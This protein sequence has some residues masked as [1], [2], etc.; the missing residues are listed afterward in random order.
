MLKIL[1]II[2]TMVLFM[3]SAAFAADNIKMVSPLTA[4]TTGKSVF[5]T[6]TATAPT[7]TAQELIGKT[8]TGVGV[9]L[10][11]S[12]LGYCLVTQHINGTKAFGSAHD[13]T[14]IFA[15][16]VTTVGTPALDV[17]GAIGV[18]PVSGAGWTSM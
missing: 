9:G 18:V 3:S 14:S 5:A 16:N 8:S 11:T 4:A 7:G 13:S 17:P 1:S 12:S 15:I 6:A 2:T 10:L